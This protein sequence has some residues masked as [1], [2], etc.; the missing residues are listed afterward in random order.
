MIANG[1][2]LS[3]F[4]RE[5]REAARAALGWPANDA[6]LLFAADPAEERKN[7]ITRLGQTEYEAF[8]KASDAVDDDWVKE[9]TGKGFNGKQLLDGAKALIQKHTK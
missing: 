6:I 7:S 9:V 5:P 8:R 2:D 3:R 1:V 4:V